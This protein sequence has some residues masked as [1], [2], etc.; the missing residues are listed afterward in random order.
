MQ[1][2]AAPLVKL[3]LY[4]RATDD[5]TFSVDVFHALTCTSA[6]DAHYELLQAYLDNQPTGAREF[7]FHGHLLEAEQLTY[8]DP[9]THVP[10][11]NEPRIV[12]LDE[13]FA[14]HLSNG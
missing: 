13:W 7:L 5:A 11:Y 12:P 2:S 4:M 3:V 1:D 8:T 14:E 9:H 6:Q 10:E